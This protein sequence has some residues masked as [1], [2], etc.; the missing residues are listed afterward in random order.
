[1]SCGTETIEHDLTFFDPLEVFGDDGALVTSGA[2]MK[3]P[4][5]FH[6]AGAAPEKMIAMAGVIKAA[7]CFVVVSPEYNH[8]IPPALSGLMGM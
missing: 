7:D 2:E 4:Y 3:A 5:H 8:S 1:M 6:A